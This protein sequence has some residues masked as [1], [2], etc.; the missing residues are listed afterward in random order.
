MDLVGLRARARVCASFIE[1]RIITNAIS[2]N[3]ELNASTSKSM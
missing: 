3:R 2:N 1:I